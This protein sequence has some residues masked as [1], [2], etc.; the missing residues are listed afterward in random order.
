MNSEFERHYHA[1][2]N[3]FSVLELNRRG[4]LRLTGKHVLDL[5]HRLS[6]NDVKNLAVDQWTTTILTTDKG[7]ILDV[8]TVLRREHHVILLCGE[9]RAEVVSAWLDKYIIMDD[10]QIENVTSKLHAYYFFGPQSFFQIKTA[11]SKIP[12]EQEILTHENSFLIRLRLFAG[13]GFL[14]FSEVPLNIPVINP[15]VLEMARIEDGYASAPREWN[16]KFNPL[17]AGLGPWINFTKGCYIGQEVIARLDAQNKVSRTLVQFQFDEI[18]LND[19][20]IFLEEKEVGVV[21]SAIQSIK[22]NTPI[23]LGYIKKDLT[24]ALHTFRIASDGKMIEARI[25]NLRSA[26]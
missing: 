14:F 26:E 19:S 17:D 6:T 18:P 20:K 23:G 21:T 11:F 15:L 4:I 16:E 8:I 22:T 24:D 2:R 13:V 1:L 25:I 10:V 7:R 3:D 5:L 12:D 9:G